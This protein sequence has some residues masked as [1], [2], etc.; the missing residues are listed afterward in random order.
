MY[1][2]KNERIIFSVAFSMP[3]S[4]I[5]YIVYEELRLEIYMDC[6]AKRNF[7]CTTHPFV[8]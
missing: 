8:R 3:S 4:F 1:M 2:Y 6:T 5:V 7:G